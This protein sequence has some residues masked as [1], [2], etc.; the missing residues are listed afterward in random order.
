M[1]KR[2]YT[3][4]SEP[5]ELARSVRKEYEKRTEDVHGAAEI[6]RKEYDRRVDQVHHTL[7]QSIEDSRQSVRKHP[8]L[9]VG[10]TLGVGIVAGVLLGRKSKA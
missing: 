3:K 6:L 4:L 2:A 1:A 8:F 10:V 7:N 9:A 5:H